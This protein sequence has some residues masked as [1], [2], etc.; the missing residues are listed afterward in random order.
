MEQAAEVADRIALAATVVPRAV[1]Q[2]IKRLTAE[3]SVVAA[4]VLAAVLD[5]HIAGTRFAKE[6]D[7][8]TMIRT[9][10]YDHFTKITEWKPLFECVKHI[11][12]RRSSKRFTIFVANNTF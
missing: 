10:T 2:D 7:H 4:G 8:G 1:R 11:S 9:H 3:P 6:L 5:A 12:I